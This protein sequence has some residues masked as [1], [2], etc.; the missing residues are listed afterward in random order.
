MAINS[1][2]NVAGLPI[3]DINRSKFDK[4]HSHKLTFNV[5]DL[6][7][8]FFDELPP[9]STVNIRVNKLVRLTSAL[10][11]P[12][13]DN[14]YFDTYFFAVPKRLVWKHFVNFMGENTEGHWYPEVEYNV[15]TIST[16]NRATLEDNES[17][18][19]TPF[20]FPYSSVADHFGIPINTYGFKV[21]AL[22][23]RA[24]ALIWNEF[25][26]DE[27]LT[28]PVNIDFGDGDKDISTYLENLMMEETHIEDYINTGSLGLS[29]L[30][31]A[32][33]KDLFTTML[34]S[35]QK[36]P[37]VTIPLGLSGLAPVISY[38]TIH[39]MPNYAKYPI[40]L[41]GINTPSGK[42]RNI[43]LSNNNTTIV[44]DST[45]GDMPNSYHN[46]YPD[47]LYTDFNLYDDD[48]HSGISV[49]LL[50]LSVATQKLLE[51]DAIFG[52]RYTELLAGHYGLL[53]A[54][55]RLQR[56]EY[57]GGS[58]FALSIDQVVQMSETSQDSPLGEVG[59]YSVTAQSDDDNIVY[60][61]QEDCFIIGLACC[62]YEHSYQQGLDKTWS[63][64]NRYEIYWP[65]LS[66][67]GEVGIKGKELMYQGEN[68][69]TWY[70]SLSSEEKLKVRQKQSFDTGVAYFTD[71]TV[72]GY[73]E[74]WYDYRYKKNYLS[75][76][77]HSGISNT[78][79][80]WH[81]ADYYNLYD[82][83]P[84]LADEWIRED[85]NIV[86]RILAI[87][88]RLSNQVMADLYF[89]Y[90]A[91]EPLPVYSIPSLTDIR[92]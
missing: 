43:L 42:Y 70:N 19:D 8:I 59:A 72:I 49:N 26:R 9:A 56:P 44:N 54:D 58:H 57:I 47:N 20:G 1:N 18:D 68:Y 24:Y 65:E 55:S 51:T 71:D 87:T 37:A 5:G 32:K 84:V 63:R 41:S 13:M 35:P 75:G 77:F 27:N 61:T 46:V 33:Y 16:G 64:S 73:Q 90:E 45:T 30:K 76:E 78:L 38:D 29:P 79:D 92:G 40:H 88:D 22:P 31:V 83:A 86:N 67:I 53:T 66:N 15:P 7:P 82:G 25:F 48:I 81:L 85:G 39:V 11:Y 34:P 69:E 52:S 80:S 6:V 3:I 10:Q 91:V 21:S 14:I 4:S 62:R 23:F 28:D 2:Y 60:S 50:R 89:E 12:I 17:A 36:G 74:A